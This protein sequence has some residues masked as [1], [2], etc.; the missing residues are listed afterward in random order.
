MPI[1]PTAPFAV[2]VR[3]D[4]QFDAALP[5]SEDSDEKKKVKPDNEKVSGADSKRTWIKRLKGG[6][7]SELVNS[8]TSTSSDETEPIKPPFALRDINI[9][10]PR[11]WILIPPSL[12]FACH[13]DDILGALVCIVGK[14]GTGKTALLLGMINEMRRLKGET[15]FGGP[16]SLVPQSAWV[17]SGTVKDNITF[18]T[19]IEEVDD[20]KLKH[21][22]AA[23][24]LEPDID[25]WQDA[26][27]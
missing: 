7:S 3:G 11:G 20:V 19:A 2:S 22:I 4:F 14:V 21:V 9:Q 23:T 1:E 15:L 6:A 16:V 27:L 8:S 12:R 17:K 13:V 18:S 10:I 24:G 25:M 5:E 26:E